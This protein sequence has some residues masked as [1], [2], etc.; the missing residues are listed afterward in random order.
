LISSSKSQDLFII[1]QSAESAFKII[2]YFRFEGYVSSACFV[3]V[4]GQ[5]RVIAMLS[6]GLMAGAIVPLQPAAN[7][8]EPI[9]EATS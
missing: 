2:G 8:I 5:T 9:P 3:K 7:R 4:D 1:K 6:N